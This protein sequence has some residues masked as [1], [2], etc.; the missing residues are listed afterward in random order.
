MA[1]W[2]REVS[3]LRPARFLARPALLDHMPD[4]LR[5]L[6]D[7][8]RPVYKAVSAHFNIATAVGRHMMSGGGGVVLCMAGGREAIPRLGGSHVAWAALGRGKVQVEFN[9]PGGERP[10]RG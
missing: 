2:E 10:E 4:F 6:A 5:E 1:R 7:F 8:V 3:R 9:R